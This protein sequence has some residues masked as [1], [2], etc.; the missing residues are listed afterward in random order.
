MCMNDFT[1]KTP[2]QLGAV[3]RGYRTSKKLS[4]QGVGMRAALPQP[5]I[6]KIESSSGRIALSRLLKVLTALDL[7]LVVR[8]KSKTNTSTEW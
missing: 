7:E 4:Q 8:P 1:I 3:L 5:I 2:K 6:S